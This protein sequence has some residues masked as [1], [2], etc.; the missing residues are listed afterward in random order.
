MK[1]QTHHNPVLRAQTY[2]LTVH[3]PP[4]DDGEEH[5]RVTPQAPSSG[6]FPTRE[7]KPPSYLSDYATQEDSGDDDSTLT[8]V[9]YCYRA[10]CG[11]PTDL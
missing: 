4:E 7:R 6:R 9:D 10:V 3:N 8:S 1:R 2:R 5:R 11:V